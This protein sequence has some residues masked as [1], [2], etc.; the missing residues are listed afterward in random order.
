MASQFREH[1][2]LNWNPNNRDG[3]LLIPIFVK[4]LESVNFEVSIKD[5]PEL[6][7]PLELMRG[8]QSVKGTDNVR[9]EINRLMRR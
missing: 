7:A 3:P 1:I 4:E 8:G 9:E 6:D 2:D 5:K